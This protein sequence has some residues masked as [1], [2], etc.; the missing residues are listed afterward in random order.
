MSQHSDAD[1]LKEL[2]RVAEL[3]HVDGPPS[4]QTFDDE[5]DVSAQIVRRRFG[6]WRAA[7]EAAD[8]GPYTQADKIPRDK[9]IAELR[10]LR[11][12]VGQIPTAEQMDDH[13]GY[14]YIT[15][16]ER[17]GSWADALEAAFG[18]VPDREWEHVSDA[19]LRAELHRLAGDD[20]SPPTTT[21]VMERGDHA[22][23]TYVDRF[24]SWADALEAAD[25]EPPTSQGVT[26]AE[27]LAE[28]RRLHDEFDTKPTTTVVRDHGVYSVPTYYNRFDSW[29]DALDA[30][31]ETVPE[32]SVGTGGA[33]TEH[34]R[35]E[36]S[37]DD[38]LEELR[39]VADVADSDGAPS[40]SEFTEHS[41]IADS[42]IHRRFGSWN[43][44]VKQAGFE[45]RQVGPT[46]SD[47]DLAAELRRLRDVVGHP[48]TVAVME[49]QGAYSSATYKNRFGSWTD[50]LTQTFDDVTTRTRAR[51]SEADEQLTPGNSAPRVSEDDLVADLQALADD[52]GRVPTSKEMRDHGSHSTS[53]YIDR[54]GSWAEAL[55][56]A[57][58]DP[59]DRSSRHQQV[60]D[61]EL[62]ADLHRLR[63]ELGQKPTATDVVEEG[64]HG[65]AT[66]QRR[67]GSWSEALDAAGIETEPDG[68]RDDELL[69]DLHRLHDER[70]K[71]PSLLDV[72]D[73]GQY[74]E[75][76]Y[77]TGFG[78]W[79][80]ALDAA[81]FDPDRGPT[82][83]ELLAE[84]RRLRDDLEKRPSMNDMTD[85][86]AYGCS[87]YQRRFGSWSGAL[88]EA[89]DTESAGENGG[90][91]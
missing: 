42:T 2:R 80:E 78:S 56:A 7:I 83:E 25:F 22:V 39:R 24:G 84:L 57:G 79:S 58:L 28:L 18:E 44:A 68:P 26:T 59:A 64:N 81:G 91:E 40:I 5:A 66:Y 35:K 12:E 19:D 1:L 15:Y 86:G 17:F 30:A 16:Y 72:Q 63:D 70:D 3:P 62:L 46:I 10:W 45:P 21:D 38:L 20:G 69:A 8:L 4:E 77:R 34:T 88:E 75:K 49:A 85:H 43:E 82:D 65:I 41:D 50:A 61:D 67:F 23:S 6:S 76:Q 53:T 90:S 32:D 87:T 13:G 74:T 89:F 31:F 33:D 11:D 36:H 47:D 60:S 71:V 14:A 9:L 52:L 27:L 55:E 51:E 29:D 37:D 48:P 73:D 54:F